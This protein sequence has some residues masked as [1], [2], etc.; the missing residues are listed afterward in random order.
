L[1]DALLETWTRGR[2]AALEKQIE[3]GGS[4]ARDQLKSLIKLYSEH[5]NPEGMAI[6]LAV[7]QWARSDATAVAAVSTVDAARLHLVESLY[8]KLGLNPAD[9][10]AQAVLFYSF[11]FGQ[12]LLFPGATS[13]KRANLIAACAD[14]LTDLKA[15]RYSR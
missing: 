11:I 13:R 2:I 8:R 7:R 5:V 12:S 6:E 4:D 10:Q 3:S 1:L 15:R 9:A 14:T